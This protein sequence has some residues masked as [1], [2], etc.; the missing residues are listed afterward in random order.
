MKEHG[1]AYKKPEGYSPIHMPKNTWAGIV[2]GGFSMVFGMAMVWHIWW[3]AIIGFIGMIAAWV[4]H[5]FVKS[6]DY[7]VQTDEIEAIENKHFDS[8]ERARRSKDRV[9]EED[10]EQSA[11]ISI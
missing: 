9:D 8:V 10:L 6:H 4:A 2:I 7:Y 3:L 11:I 1:L 5:S